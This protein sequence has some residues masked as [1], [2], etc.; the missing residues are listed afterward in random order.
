PVVV[1]VPID[2]LVTTASLTRLGI[3]QANKPLRLAHLEE[4]LREAVA[5]K[6]TRPPSGAAAS[7]TLGLRILLAED[8]EVNVEVALAMLEIF[9]CHV[10]VAHDGIAAVKAWSNSEFDLVL[11]DCMMPGMDGY[12]ATR[13]IRLLES[14]SG[15]GPKPIIAVTGNAMPEDK[16]R[17]FEA[18]MTDYMSKPF[19]LEQL[20][21]VLK[22]I[23]QLIGAPASPPSR[24]PANAHSP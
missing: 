7:R 12:S 6:L 16:A 22:N 9:G 11:M 17:C 24:A 23:A 13:E 18:G 19:S 10:E 14:I 21:G 20:E 4:A 5:G 2:Q 15:R 3:A 1:C 8:N